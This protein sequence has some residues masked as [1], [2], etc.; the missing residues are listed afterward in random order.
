[1]PP[2]MNLFA[3]VSLVITLLS[4]RPWVFIVFTGMSLGT[5]VFS[6]YLFTKGHAG[7]SDS[8]YTHSPTRVKLRFV[9]LQHLLW[10]FLAPLPLS[11]FLP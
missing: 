9:G 7:R 4:H 1:V 3:E 10:L 8:Q 5:F 2:S 11:T 6:L